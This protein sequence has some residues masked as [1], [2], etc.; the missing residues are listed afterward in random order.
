MAEQYKTVLT[1]PWGEGSEGYTGGSYFSSH[2]PSRTQNDINS[3]DLSYACV[4]LVFRALNLRCDA[5]R[6]VPIYIYKNNAIIKKG[7]PYEDVFPI[8][9][10]LW[11]AEA[12]ELLAGAS[13]TLRLANQ[14]GFEKGLT[15]LNP[16]TVN[17]EN[18]WMD[19]R[20]IRFYQQINNQRY[21][22]RG[23]W[24]E[25]QVIYWRSYSPLNDVAP[26]VSAAGVALG[27]S[28]LLHYLTRFLS[29]Y[30][31]KGAMPV[32]LAML[33]AGASDDQQKAVQGYFKRVMTGVKNAFKVLAV[34]GEIKVE[35]LTPDLATFEVQKLD[36]HAI[37]NIAWAFN[38]PKTL[39]T[40]DSATRATAETEYSNFLSQTIAS[41]CD[42]YET[43]LNKFLDDFG[44]SC[45]FA[46]EELPEMQINETVRAGSLKNLVDS[47]MPL[48]TAM[49][50]LGYTLSEER[51]KEM[52]DELAKPPP[53]LPTPTLRQPSAVDKMPAEMPKQ[54]MPVKAELD[55]WYRKSLKLFKAGKAARCEFVSDVIP[56]EVYDRIKATLETINTEEELK[57]VFE[58]P[59]GQTK[60]S[61]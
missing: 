26:G 20:N 18:S 30:F 11:M 4:P 17:D 28:Q 10:W 13:Y 60:N 5:L 34:K 29:Q 21:P 3:T 52:E 43:R 32:T 12:S 49:Y 55:K 15:F 46:I 7:Y 44:M 61:H 8:K 41:R 22:E 2:S 19:K 1:I 59:N 24:S 53:A 40:S 45:E 47:G 50:I 38:I 48:V 9:D 57:K 56:G 42:T 58:E 39:L 37:D 27:N 16:F 6:R 25:E 51:Q 31:E 35:K 14:W 54:D 33:P 23:T 36:T